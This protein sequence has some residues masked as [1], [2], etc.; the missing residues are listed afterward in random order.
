MMA[1]AAGFH[2]TL[3]VDQTAEWCN[4]EILVQKPNGNVRHCLDPA[5]LNQE[6]IRSI[7]RD[8]TVNDMLPKIM[9]VQYL[10]LIDISSGYHSLQLDKKSSYLTTFAY[11]FGG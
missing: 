2:N 1:A 5:T 6:L 10:T 11:Q 4:S 9:H 3:G 7:H 8:P